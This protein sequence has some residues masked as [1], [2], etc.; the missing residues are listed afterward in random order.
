MAVLEILA[1]PD[2]RLKQTSQPVTEFDA[3]LRRFLADLEATM[4]AAPGGVGLAA[5]Q[6]GR[7]QRVVIVDV[8]GRPD[9]P[10]NGRMILI[11]PEVTEREGEAVGREGCLSVPDYTGNVARAGRSRGRARD[12]DGAFREFED[13]GKQAR[14]GPP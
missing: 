7:P 13:E 5:P 11:N 14:A 2:A 3:D 8:S 9:I 10:H 12:A 4:R 1:Y 6:A